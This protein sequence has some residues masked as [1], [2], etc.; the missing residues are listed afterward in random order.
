MRE[1]A[2]A[3]VRDTG[4]GGPVEE[5]DRVAVPFAAANRGAVWFERLL[6]LVFDRPRA[7]VPFG[8]GIDR[9]LGPRFAASAVAPA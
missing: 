4:V 3:A 6:E 9:C 8:F 5:G 1:I 7:P 2:G